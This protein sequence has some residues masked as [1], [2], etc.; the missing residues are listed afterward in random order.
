MASGVPALEGGVALI[1]PTRQVQVPEA[2]E[3]VA[4]ASQRLRSD[5]HAFTDRFFEMELGRGLFDVRDADGVRFWDILRHDLY[6]LLWA[7]VSGAAHAIRKSEPR[8]SVPKRLLRNALCA[9]RMADVQR[10]IRRS[11][12]EYLFLTTSRLS[13]ADGM[14][15]PISQPYLELLPGRCFVL[16]TFSKTARYL[17]GAAAARG[18]FAS[19]PQSARREHRLGAAI[20]EAFREYFDLQLDPIALN[21]LID[22]NLGAYQDQLR[23]FGRVLQTHRPTAVVMVANGI[24]KGLFTTARRLD[25]PVIELQ[26]GLISRLHPYYSYPRGP[27]YRE[28]QMHPDLLLTFASSWMTRV[29]FADVPTVATGTDYYRPRAGSGTR[30]GLLIV[31]ADR[32]HPVLSAAAKTIA[33]RLPQLPILYKLHPQQYDRAQ[34]IGAEFRGHSNITVHA[35]ARP[36]SDLFTEVSAMMCIQSTVVYEALQV[37]L[38]VFVVPRDNY[39]IHEDVFEYVELCEDASLVADALERPSA[40]KVPELS[41]FDRFDSAAALRVLSNPRAS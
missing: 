35:G 8:H 4:G 9:L 41:F 15:D 13:A 18:A 1:H 2:G 33:A 11:R 36:I 3:P 24:L 34:A 17:R 25:I 6:S 19:I 40:S 28:L 23:Y 14:T 30:P 38:R 12:P 32:Y 31:S 29:H 7:H 37:G 27:Q 16:E 22:G 20:N 5:A 26:H 21:E 10:K 39:Q